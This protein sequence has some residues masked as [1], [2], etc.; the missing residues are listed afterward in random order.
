[1][2]IPRGC[3]PFG[4]VASAASRA[5]RFSCPWRYYLARSVR[6]FYHL[7][8]CLRAW[9][10]LC[11]APVATVRT[12]HVFG[13]LAFAWDNRYCDESVRISHCPLAIALPSP[14][15]GCCDDGSI[16]AVRSELP[17]A[18]IRPGSVSDGAGWLVA[19]SNGRSGFLPFGHELI[20]LVI[21]RVA[22]TF[23][24]KSCENPRLII[25]QRDHTGHHTRTATGEQR[26][27]VW[28]PGPTPRIRRGSRERVHAHILPQLFASC[29][30]LSS[31]LRQDVLPTPPARKCPPGLAL[32]SAATCLACQIQRPRSLDPVRTNGGER[33]ADRT[34]ALTRRGP[35]AAGPGRSEAGR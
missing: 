28:R 19:W 4:L 17:V 22:R 10:P 29:I 23:V 33:E 30:L 15:T 13:P 21:G 35:E 11:F 26:E 3:T 25:T 2:Q 6:A 20:M 18:Q 14:M 27:K 31:V 16:R 12:R 8:V 34:V 24:T 32:R 5:E 7:L 9:R 1:M